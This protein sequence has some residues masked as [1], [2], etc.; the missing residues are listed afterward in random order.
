[1][2]AASNRLRRTNPTTL[3]WRSMRRVERRAARFVQTRDTHPVCG[4]CQR[5][6]LALLTEAVRLANHLAWEA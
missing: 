2:N 1:M 5:E 3:Y 4:D 6:D